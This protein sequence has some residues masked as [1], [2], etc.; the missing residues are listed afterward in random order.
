MMDDLLAPAPD[1]VL[2]VTDLTRRIKRILEGEIGRVWVRGEVSNLRRQSSGHVYFSLK[3]KG[4]QLPC[5]LFARDAARQSFQLNDGME[6]VLF[7]ELSVYAPHG[8][9]QLIAKVA[10]Q[11]GEGR[12]QLEFERLKR[13]LAAEGLFDA[14]RKR[15]LPT[16]PRRIAVDHLTNGCRLTRFPADSLAAGLCR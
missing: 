14:E 3:D 9:Y 6:L 13:K 11:S 10:I 5:V 15:E 12:L 8:R 1:D 7:G 16:L 4:S 2:A